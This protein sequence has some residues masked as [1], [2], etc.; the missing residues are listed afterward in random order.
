VGESLTKENLEAEFRKF[1]PLEDFKLLRDRNSALAEFKNIQDA[2]AAVKGLNKKLIHGD[3][4]RVDFLRSQPAK[5]VKFCCFSH[6]SIRT[7][8]FEDAS[9]FSV[10]LLVQIRSI[11]WRW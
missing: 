3:E 6:V 11:P 5:R 8:L 7:V 2:S 1:G 4:L 10:V 9:L